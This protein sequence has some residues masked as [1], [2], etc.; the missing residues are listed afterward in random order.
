[1]PQP[2]APS[3]TRLSL[4]SSSP[5]TSRSRASSSGAS[6]IIIRLTSRLPSRRTWDKSSRIVRKPTGA[7]FLCRTSSSRPLR[8]MRSGTPSGSDGGC[9]PMSVRLIPIRRTTTILGRNNQPSYRTSP[10]SQWGATSSTRQRSVS[11]KLRSV[12]ATTSVWC[13][14]VAIP[15]WVT[16]LTMMTSS[17]I[18]TSR[19]A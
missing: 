19:R 14:S 1:M 6:M 12:C 15:A 7:G 16:I 3:R 9:R 18:V 17:S 10:R 5:S 2:S 11:Y 13:R 4:P 8:S